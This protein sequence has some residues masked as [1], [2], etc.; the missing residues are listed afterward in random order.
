MQIGFWN[1]LKFPKLFASTE[2]ERSV[3]SAVLQEQSLGSTIMRTCFCSFQ[4]PTYFDTLKFSN[5]VIGSQMTWSLVL[6]YI[7]FPVC[8]AHK[9]MKQTDAFTIQD[10]FNR[11]T[12]ANIV[13]EKLHQVLMT[14]QVP[15][16]ANDISDVENR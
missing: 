14:T 11:E 16:D 8:T 13:Q 3:Y 7:I 1:R 9:A 6:L 2:F 5:G 10:T 4:V 12:V 15:Q